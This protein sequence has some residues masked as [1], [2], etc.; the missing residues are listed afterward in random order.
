MAALAATDIPRKA[1]LIARRRSDW[2]KLREILE[3][4]GVELPP[5]PQPTP[6]RLRM[7]EEAEARITT[8]VDV[9][10]F[11]DQKREALA[12]HASQIAESWFG[13][14]PPEAYHTMFGNE[15]FIRAHDTT[16]AAAPED[17]LFAGLL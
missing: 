9:S 15:T 11:V 8:S 2:A 10:V 12:T 16:G 17:D 1:Y 6:E 7:M 13:K 14:L 3:A 4:H 5:M